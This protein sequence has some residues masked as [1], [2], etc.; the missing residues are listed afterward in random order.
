MVYFAMAE[1]LE[2]CSQFPITEDEAEAELSR[3]RGSVA[4]W[5]EMGIYPF[6]KL[7]LAYLSVGNGPN[8]VACFLLAGI[9]P[10]AKNEQLHRKREKCG[11]LIAIG[12][13]VRLGYANA[14]RSRQPSGRDPVLIER[15]IDGAINRTPNCPFIPDAGHASMPLDG[16]VVGLHQSIEGYWLHLASSASVQSKRA[17][18]SSAAFIEMS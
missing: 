12:K 1:T 17:N 7:R 4:G 3:L 13:A 15:N 18:T 10:V 9:K 14:H 2:R 11:A 5:Q 8:D 6:G 16:Q